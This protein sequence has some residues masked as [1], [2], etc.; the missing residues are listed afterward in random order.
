M[1]EDDCLKNS[2]KFDPE[3]YVE[4]ISHDPKAEYHIYYCDKG[5][6]WKAI[7]HILRHERYSSVFYKDIDECKSDCVIWIRDYLNCN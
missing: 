3:D 7:V 2:I 6:F 1:A 4:L 5:Y